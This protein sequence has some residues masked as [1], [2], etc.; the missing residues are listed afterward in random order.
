MPPKK[1]AEK[2]ADVTVTDAVTGE[3]VKPDPEDSKGT[4]SV[5]ALRQGSRD[6]DSVRRLQTALGAHPSGN[7]GGRTAA[8]VAEAVGEGSGRYVTK[9][10]AKK[11]L[12][13][14][15]KVVD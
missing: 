3:E 4:V 8:L 13:S 1:K 10:Q 9:A 11:I 5:N 2:K 14:G 12:G 7:Y 6:S 15:Y